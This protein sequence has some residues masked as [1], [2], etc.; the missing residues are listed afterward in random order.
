MGK[1]TKYKLSMGLAF[2]EVNEMN[3]LS[4]MAKQGWRFYSYIFPGYKFKKSEPI[5]LVYCVDTHV[6]NRDEEE[7][8]FSIFKD[9]G[10]THVCSAGNVF[11]YFSAAPGTR[12]IYT[13]KVTLAEKY[14]KQVH[15]IN[16][17]LILLA[18]AAVGFIIFNILINRFLGD[19]IFSLIVSML[20]GGLIGCFAAATVTLAVIM[21]KSRKLS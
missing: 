7:Q 15:Y 5:D 11:H 8:Y 12:P 13:D 18:P 9:S 17:S 10:W 14:K 16:K 6:V 3:M 21:L 20:S 4:K 19:S 1:M 2:N